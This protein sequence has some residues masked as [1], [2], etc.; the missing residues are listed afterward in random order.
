MIRFGT[1]GWRGVVGQ[2]FTFRNV[3]LL[4]DAIAG[5][6]RER[7]ETGEVL[8]SYDTRLLSEKFAR[9]AVSVLTHHGLPA[10]LSERDLPAPC[11]A[12]ATRERKASLGV[13]FTASHN[14]PE[15]NGV[16]L[17][18]SA[19]VSAPRELL[20]AIEA[21]AARREAGFAD[22]FV[23]QRHLATTAPLASGYLD[24]LD[25][26]LDWEAIQA[27]GLVVAVD[28]LFGTAREFLDRV[29]LA[30]GIPTHVVHTTKDPYFGG[31]SPECS[32]QNLAGLRELVRS[33]GAQL[34]LATDGDADRFGVI[35]GACRAISPNLA[36]ALAV[37]YLVRRRGVVGG[38]GRTIGTTRLV[39]RVARAAG[40]EVI[41]TAVGFHNFS[42]LF[43]SRQVAIAAEESAGLGV[44]AHLPERDGI[45]AALLMAEMVAVERC[46]I[47]ELVKR[48]FGRFGVLLSRRVQLPWNERSR[49]ALAALSGRDF[50]LFAGHRVVRVDRR[51]GV[52]L[53]LEGGGWVLLR[54]AGT[55]PKL[56]LY[57]E[58][59]SS[60]Q[61][62]ALV[63]EARRLVREAE[64]G[65]RHV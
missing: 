44:A 43:L 54:P 48:L 53:E 37:D 21:T 58:G 11:V 13:I 16:K 9:E 47:G 14:P 52:L 62:R 26:D 8:V 24:S 33:S 63:Q 19:G 30:H 49:A 29:L 15:Y 1:S 45:F 10:V 59:T 32:P 23:P 41:E 17:Y 12:Y 40:L 42:P 31:Y 61:L 36:I 7:G 20:D 39:D 22:F 25:R 28:P 51:D 57:A 5:V 55:E 65:A 56:R 60:R 27:S 6:L 3:R 35:D 38:V 34:G 18:T 64:E 2:D 46:S 50:K 4:L